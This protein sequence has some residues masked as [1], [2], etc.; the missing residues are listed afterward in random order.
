MTRTEPQKDPAHHRSGNGA[1]APTTGVPN[2]STSLQ[3]E[4][5][6]RGRRSRP[7]DN[8]SGKS[9]D[10]AP[11][12][13]A[14]QARAVDE[15]PTGP[16]RPPIGPE[17]FRALDQ[18]RC[19]AGKPGEGRRPEGDAGMHVMNDQELRGSVISQ[20]LG[21]CPS[22]HAPSRQRDEL[23]VAVR[24]AICT[25]GVRSVVP[26]GSKTP[27]M[28]SDEYVSD[29]LIATMNWLKHHEGRARRLT[30]LRLFI[31]LRGVATKNGSGSARHAQSDE[32]RGFSNV[33]AGDR[34]RFVDCDISELDL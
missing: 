17:V 7:V 25:R 34:I 5:T 4:P 32:L 6:A 18:G 8:S 10:S 29:E 30:P 20:A 33:A 23:W 19:I 11:M 31:T 26:L 14:H 16:H 13:Q 24:S 27:V 22:L 2:T 21:R 1:D 28:V 12:G 15:E 9:A 3:P